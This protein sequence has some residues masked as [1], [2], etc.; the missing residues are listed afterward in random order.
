[1]KLKW[2]ALALLTLGLGF[3]TLSIPA[4]QP[5]CN[6]YG[7]VQVFGTI[8]GVLAA[9]YGGLTLATTHETTHRNNAKALIEG[10]VIGLIVIWLAP[11]VITN[12]VGA[13]SVCGWTS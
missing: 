6:L 7:M 12:L 11:L 4:N 8:L 5:I 1:M 13:T 3:A 9:S 2:L 10:A